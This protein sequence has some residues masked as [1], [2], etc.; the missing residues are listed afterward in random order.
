V[1]LLQKGFDL[2]DEGND[3]LR[4]ADLVRDAVQVLEDAAV[5]LLQHRVLKTILDQL[6]LGHL[7]TTAEVERLHRKLG[8][9]LVEVV[10]V[11]DVQVYDRTGMNFF[12]SLEI[13]MS[14]E[15]RWNRSG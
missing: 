4:K 10:L 13:R 11:E 8:G 15:Q 12:V 6:R 9:L 3:E 5:H 2:E 7:E 1:A 14:W